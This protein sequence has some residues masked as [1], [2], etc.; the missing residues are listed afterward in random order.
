MGFG[1]RAEKGKTEPHENRSHVLGLPT[2]GS[3]WRVLA[4]EPQASHIHSEP[5]V[6]HAQI[7]F[8][9]RRH[10]L[11]F[12]SCS[13]LDLPLILFQPQGEVSHPDSD[14]PGHT[15]F[16]VVP[17][18]ILLQDSK[19]VQAR[20]GPTCLS[21]HVHTGAHEIKPAAVE[22]GVVRV[23]RRLAGGRA[24]SHAAQGATRWLAGLVRAAGGRLTGHQAALLAVAKGIAPRSRIEGLARR[25]ID[26]LVQAATGGEGQA[27]LTIERK[28]LITH[29]ALVAVGATAPRHREVSAG[30]RAA[31]GTQ[32]VV[33]VGRAA[34][35]CRESVRIENP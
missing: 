23:S 7:T 12:R 4:W 33:T 8:Y 16:P 1:Q 21:Q 30:Q 27:G 32:L 34:Q 28:A 26:A 9:P 22:G 10:P 14:H 19:L 35:C 24:H 25:V 6:S 3:D 29:A 18:H 5:Q 11:R 13:H 15:D 31:T 17:L 2:P 20:P